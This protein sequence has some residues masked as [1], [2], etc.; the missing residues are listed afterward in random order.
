LVLPPG[1]VAAENTANFSDPV[2]STIPI[3]PPADSAPETAADNSS[4]PIDSPPQTAILAEEAPSAILEQPPIAA[5]N[6]ADQIILQGED[7]ISPETPAENSVSIETV[8]NANTN[9][10]ANNSVS[11]APVSIPEEAPYPLTEPT[12]AP[13]P[14]PA[15]AL[16]ADAPAIIPNSEI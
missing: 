6:I 7:L 4:P 15:P 2:L 8:E 14:E 11:T 3:S 9:E 16:L 5:E 12:P 1:D 13:S 10:T